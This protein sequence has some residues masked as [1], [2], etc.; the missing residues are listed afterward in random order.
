MCKL[1]FQVQGKRLK[2]TN[3]SNASGIEWGD[4]YPSGDRA[5]DSSSA[6][7][8]FWTILLNF[9]PELPERELRYCPPT[10]VV[11][12]RSTMWTFLLL[13]LQARD[14]IVYWSRR[15]FFV[16]CCAHQFPTFRGGHLPGI[17]GIDGNLVVNSACCSTWVS[18]AQYL[19]QVDDVL[20]GRSLH[21]KQNFVENFY[22]S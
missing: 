18:L 22:W 19:P 21:P 3:E 15:S 20:Q 8:P 11:S 1:N 14:V 5:G 13:W 4:V 16:V 10:V 9:P 6:V 7:E 2:L 17:A 12:A